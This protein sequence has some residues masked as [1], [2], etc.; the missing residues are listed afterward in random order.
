MKNISNTPEYVV[1]DDVAYSLSVV[2]GDGQSGTSALKNFD[3][4]YVHGEVDSLP[5]GTGA[6][7]K[8]KSLLITSMVTDINPNSNWTSISYKLNDDT[9]GPYNDNSDADNG[10]TFYTTLIAFK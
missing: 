9:I 1:Q 7:I 6:A 3:G 8:G 2:I 10:S 5:L 4:K